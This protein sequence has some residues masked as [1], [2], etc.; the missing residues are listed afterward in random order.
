VLKTRGGD[1]SANPLK[2]LNTLGAP[3]HLALFSAREWGGQAKKSAPPHPAFV[4]ATVPAQ[5]APPQ[6]RIRP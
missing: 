2:R 5:G 1:A 6:P 3:V 4:V